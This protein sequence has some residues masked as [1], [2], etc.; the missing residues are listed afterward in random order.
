MKTLFSLVEDGLHLF[1]PHVCTGCGTDLIQK[2]ILLCHNCINELPETAFCS[3]K[4]NP[5]EKMFF[6]RIAVETAGSVYYFTKGSVLQHL[7]HELK[8]KGNKDIGC[9]LGE[10]MGISLTT[11]GRFGDID[12]VVPLPMYR[13]KEMKRGYNQATVIA[14]GIAGVMK[15]P[16]DETSVTRNRAT[17]TQTRKDRTERW[18]NA[19]N[20]FSVNDKSTLAGKH[21]LLVDDVITTGATLEVCGHAIKHIPDTRLSIVT[22]AYAVK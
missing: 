10:K 6:G 19:D 7:I 20:S 13:D 18:L 12:I 8:Y 22:L 11:S 21:I 15:V 4:D 3:I 14:K 16:V 5:V 2:D 9:W 1:Y 17:E